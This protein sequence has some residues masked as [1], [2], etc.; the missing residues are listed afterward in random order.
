MY[1]IIDVPGFL[2]ATAFRDYGGQT[3]EVALRVTDTFRP[4]NAGVWRLSFRDGAS[5]GPGTPE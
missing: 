5:T 3:A 4:G 1:R 2:A